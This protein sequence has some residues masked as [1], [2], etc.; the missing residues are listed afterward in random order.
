MELMAVVLVVGI[1]AATA[2]PSAL[3]A[4][5]SYTLSVAAD[6]LAQQLNRC[7]QEAVRLNVPMRIR[8]AEHHSRID[9]DRDGNF[10]SE[11]GPVVSFGGAAAVTT[12]VPSD[13][14]VTFTSR[15]ELPIG[16][17][18]AFTITSSG[19]DRVVSI[20]PLGAVDV[21]PESPAQ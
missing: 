11:D 12:M 15:G 21:G 7:R 9:V 18:P 13:G 16:V 4:Y 10:D 14:V 17:S 5:R 2:I 20:D 1:I 6:A 3:S 19:Y 8:V